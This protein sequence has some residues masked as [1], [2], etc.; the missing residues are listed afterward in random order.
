MI[1]IT[2][3]KLELSS[4]EVDFLPLRQCEGLGYV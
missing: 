2:A 4:Q 1:I 3:E